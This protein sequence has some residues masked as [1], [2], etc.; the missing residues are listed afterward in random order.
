MRRE[1][2]N[3]NGLLDKCHC[4][5]NAKIIFDGDDPLKRWRIDC[6]ECAETTGWHTYPDDAFTAWNKKIREEGP[7]K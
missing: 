4:G 1:I 5:A 2:I 3:T 6:A 7:R